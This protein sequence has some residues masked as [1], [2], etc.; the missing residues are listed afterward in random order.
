M[1]SRPMQIHERYRRLRDIGVP[2]LVAIRRA[3]DP[4]D[5]CDTFFTITSITKSLGPEWNVSEVEHAGRKV[6]VTE[7]PGNPMFIAWHDLDHPRQ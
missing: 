1:T 3:R 6:L 5:Q 7:R 2:A 4:A